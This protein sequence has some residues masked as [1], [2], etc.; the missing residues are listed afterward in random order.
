MYCSSNLEAENYFLMPLQP[1]LQQ[2][3]HQYFLCAQKSRI[4]K[5]NTTSGK[6][7]KRTNCSSY[8]VLY[9]NSRKNSIPRRMLWDRYV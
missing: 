7:T 4:C 5:T 8:G 6:D 3:H 2:M 1:Y 9:V